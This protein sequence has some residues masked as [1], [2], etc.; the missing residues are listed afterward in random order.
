MGSWW[1]HS[2]MVVG[3]CLWWVKRGCLLVLSHDVDDQLLHVHHHHHHRNWWR[4][5]RTTGHV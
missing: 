2:G 5:Q 3:G 1:D 4:L